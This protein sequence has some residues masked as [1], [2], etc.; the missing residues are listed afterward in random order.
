MMLKESR[1]EIRLVSPQSIDIFLLC[2]TS[3]ERMLFK[4][5]IRMKNVVVQIQTA[6]KNKFLQLPE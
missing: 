3:Q 2:F 6:N 1:R 5:L 4:S